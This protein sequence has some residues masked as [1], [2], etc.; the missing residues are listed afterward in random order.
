MVTGWNSTVEME[1]L[2]AWLITESNIICKCDLFSIWMVIKH[3]CVT[4]DI[5]WLIWN[6]SS[7]HSQSEALFPGYQHRKQTSLFTWTHAQLFSDRVRKFRHR[8][9]K[10]LNKLDGGKIIINVR[11]DG[12]KT[13]ESLN[14]NYAVA[15]LLSCSKPLQEPGLRGLHLQL[16]SVPLI[17]RC[18]F[19][20]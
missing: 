12:Y 8:Q 5:K 16:F 15:S 7:G 4:L 13:H 20:S 19:S 3:I 6:D 17:Y 18:K 1:R 2:L 10:S 11:G 14:T 9:R